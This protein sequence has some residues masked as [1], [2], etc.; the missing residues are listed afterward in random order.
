MS[1]LPNDVQRHVAA[2]EE[3]F[4]AENSRKSYEFIS[5]GV[6]YQFSTGGKRLRPALCLMACEA[7]GGDPAAA[8][9]FA[10][11][12][13]I[14]HNFLLV[15]DDIED[16][17]TMRRDQKTLWAKIGVPNAINVADFM[18]CRAY[19]L[20]LEAPLP[21]D[22]N[23]RLAQQ[24]SLTFQRTVQGQALDINL[25]GNV[26][27]DLEIYFR[28][29]THKTAFYLALPW[30]GGAIVAGVSDD[31]LEPLWELGRCL[32][33]AFQIK[34]DLI[35]LTEGKGRGGEVGCD[36]REGK[37]SICYAYALS[38][39]RG[40]EE[41]RRRLVDIVRAPR[42]ETSPSDIEW[43]IAFF[44][45]QGVLEFAQS[46]ADRLAAQSER[47]LEELPFG[48]AGKAGFREMIRFIVQRKF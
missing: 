17:D 1:D 25:R 11:A 9:P 35:D 48:D 15:H 4:H 36:I 32:G 28:I 45:E 22:I 40:S 14:L 34:D 29:V 41:D 3:Y 16:G 19:R 20:I 13:E 6:N 42:E 38:A 30:V 24:F 18:I 5:D 8:L 31:Q 33:P 23:L 47:V 7:L 12:T 26:E 46:E 43:V 37:P 44:D 2:L 10:M 39:E 21:S 27:V